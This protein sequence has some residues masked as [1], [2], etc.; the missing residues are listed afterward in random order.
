MRAGFGR[1]ASWTELPALQLSGEGLHGLVEEVAD[2]GHR[3]AGDLGDLLVA[4]AFLDLQQDQLTITRAQLGDRRPNLLPGLLSLGLL[5]GSVRDTHR[6]F[7]HGLQGLPSPDG[8]PNVIDADIANDPDKPVVA[9]VHPYETTRLLGHAQKGLLHDVLGSQ[10][11]GQKARGE[12]QKTLLISLDE[13]GQ[14]LDVPGVRVGREELLIGHDYLG[15]ARGGLAAIDRMSR[16][17]RAPGTGW[18]TGK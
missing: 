12:A 14:G 9:A 7:G 4:L 13:H 8:F 3:E 5:I 17:G 11:I 10:V 2:V 15:L 6:V 1:R 18:T 16:H